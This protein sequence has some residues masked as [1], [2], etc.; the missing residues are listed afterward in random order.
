MTETGVSIHVPPVQRGKALILQEDV[1]ALP[2]SPSVVGL[3]GING[4]GKSTFFL[5][6]AGLLECR[7]RPGVSLRGGAPES[8][9]FLPQTPALPTWLTT[10]EA[11]E[12]YGLSF[13]DLTDRFPGLLLSELAGKPVAH[14]SEG[15]V[16]ALS[17]ALT[18][19]ADARV[20]LLDEPLSALDLR[21]RRGFR[22][23]LSEW[24]KSVAG[25]RLM[26]ISTQST[27]EIMDFC[28]AMVVLHEGRSR[29][30]GSLDQ[31]V[32]GLTGTEA[33]IR[34]AVEDRLVSLLE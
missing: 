23:H 8:F 34:S 17:L 6:L 18:L 16:Q 3:L 21:R 26:I 10:E 31:I 24:R 13:P 1:W 5:S 33:D 7:S 9:A 22:E 27:S 25:G 28:E 14:L 29:F 15:Q 20:T 30:C 2:G 12:T 19:G 11:T 32:D 4:A